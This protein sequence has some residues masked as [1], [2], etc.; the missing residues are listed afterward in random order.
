[1]QMFRGTSRGLEWHTPRMEQLGGK[2]VVGVPA[3]YKVPTKLKG[4][5]VR[6]SDLAVEKLRT[7]K[8]AT[9]AKRKSRS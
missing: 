1:M 3:D 5:L 2:I 8:K 4:Q 9:K 6:L 7:A